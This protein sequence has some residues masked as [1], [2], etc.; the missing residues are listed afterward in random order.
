MVDEIKITSLSGRGSIFFKNREYSG[1]W[2][3]RQNTTWGQAEGQHQTYSY[4]NQVGESIVSTTVGTR[5][6]SIVGWVTDG[7]GD[8]QER[9]DRLNAFISPVEDYTLEVKGKKINFRPD[10]SI[11]YSREYMSNNEKARKFLIQG[12]CPYP[13][14]TDLEDTEIPFGG[15]K[16]LF[17]FPTDFGRVAPIVFSVAGD[18]SGITVENKGGFSTGFIVNIRFSGEIKNPK[19]VNA[20]TSRMIGVNYTFEDG[21]RLEISTMPGNKHIFM[22]NSDGEKSDLIKYRDYKTS[23]DTQLQPGENL[24]SIETDSGNRADMDV[25]LLYTPLYLEVE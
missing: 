7:G 24:I 23:F 1:Y 12:T 22:W 6:L 5:P 3:D 2:L 14:F 18:V 20:N 25:I 19:I 16:K 13:L 9:C 17:R 8:I 11:I 15:T 4:L 21:D 10:C